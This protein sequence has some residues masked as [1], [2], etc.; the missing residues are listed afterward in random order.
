MS[1]VLF[2]K[3]IFEEVVLSGS[4]PPQGE[5][6][7]EHATAFGGRHGRVVHWSSIPRYGIYFRSIYFRRAAVDVI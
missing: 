5:G 7:G 6:G 1:A 3:E 2:L 4:H